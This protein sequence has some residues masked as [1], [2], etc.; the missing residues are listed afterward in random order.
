[1]KNIYFFQ[2]SVYALFDISACKCKNFKFCNCSNDKKIPQKIQYFL[3]DQRNKRKLNIPNEIACIDLNEC[4]ELANEDIEVVPSFEESDENQ[5]DFDTASN[6]GNEFVPTVDKL[7]EN[8]QLR[9][10]RSIALTYENTSSR[11]MIKL[12]Q[13]AITADRYKVKNTVVAAIGNSILMDYNVLDHLNSKNYIDPYKIRRQR[14]MYRNLAIESH[15]N[16][17]KPTV[18][19]YFDGKTD[20]TLVYENQKTVTK[21]QHHIALV[22]QPGNFYIGH[23]TTN[24]QASAIISQEILEYLSKNSISTDDIVVVGCDGC[25]EN[26]GRLN[27]AIRLIEK[28]IGHPVQRQICLLHC[29]E[30]PLKNTMLHH[31]GVSKGPNTLDG[32]IGKRLPNCEKLPVVKFDP[33]PFHC[34]VKD[35]SKIAKSLSTDQMYMYDICNAISNGICDSNLANRDAG[36]LN[37]ARFTTTANHICRLYV[38][39]I[40]PSRTLINLVKYILWVYAPAH[41]H[42][43]Y[44][45]S[46]VYGAIHLFFIIQQLRLIDA[47]FIQTIRNTISRNCFHLHP[48]NL[49]LAMLNDDDEQIRYRG[50]KKILEIKNAQQTEEIRIFNLP[51]INFDAN[52]YIELIDFDNEMTTIPPILMN[53]DLSINDAKYYAQKKLCEHDLGFDI[54]N[55]PCHTQSVERCVKIV[56]EASISVCGEQR[57]NGFIIN[58][59]QSRNNMPIFRNKRDFNPI[60]GDVSQ[61]SI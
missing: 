2:L 57:R 49:V 19:L 4:V 60:H 40:K 44:E 18:G 45:S 37:H 58:T 16:N 54:M 33:I 5:V 27:G 32:P 9:S 50:W 38:S 20:E 1:M 43:K 15:R 26:T 42:I 21:N 56:T 12:P 41:F 51:N 6:S 22:Q 36:N 3:H 24:G 28:K 13:T 53:F 23:V 59:L 55:L 14:E 39:T 8:H 30:L 29:T 31:D 47:N 34:N 7:N 61:V 48:E 52:N 10:G 17:M 25:P 35:I 11:N 46:C